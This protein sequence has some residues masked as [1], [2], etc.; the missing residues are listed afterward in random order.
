MVGYGAAQSSAFATLCERYRQRLFRAAR[1]IS[2]CREDAED[3][4]QDAL[5][6]AF[7]HIG[8]FD[9]RSSLPTW[10]TRIAI[11]SALM[12][13]RKNRAAPQITLE[14]NDDFARDGLHHGILDRAPNPESCYAQTEAQGI[15]REA[16][17]RLRPKQRAVVQI[18]L[19]GRSMQETAEAIGISLAAVKGRLFHAKAALRSSP[20]LK[21]T[22]RH[23]HRSECGDAQ[24]RLRHE[25]VGA[26]EGLTIPRIALSPNQRSQESQH[27]QGGTFGS[28]SPSPPNAY[29]TNKLAACPTVYK[30][31]TNK[32][33]RASVG[34]LRYCSI[35]VPPAS[36]EDLTMG[37]DSNYCWVVLCKN[38]RF[39][40]RQNRFFR[41]RIT[42]GKTDAVAP[43]PSFGK[44]FT[45]RCDEC[46]K[47]YAY[48]PKDVLRA[49][50]ELPE[51]FKPHPLFQ[52]EPSEYEAFTDR[53]KAN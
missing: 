29:L 36:P 26:S 7:V 5:L 47:T 49:E 16:V 23:R 34:L 20:I 8:D 30:E 40:M 48:R 35:L 32:L 28:D 21:L 13:L 43:L 46:G 41:H 6:N 22:R 15:M 4:V 39:H 50:Q 24:W 53:P 1:R 42:L 18:Q 31:L 37:E 11:N 38:H 10:L 33:H 14:G 51:S 52:E 12:I 9:G 2:R 17:Q 25:G 44:D 19:Q 27:P 3:A 45:V